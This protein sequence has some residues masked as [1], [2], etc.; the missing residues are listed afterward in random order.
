[1]V[2]PAQA[3]KANSVIQF[4]IENCVEIFGEEV[5]MLLEYEED[6]GDSG[7]DTDSIPETNGN[8]CGHL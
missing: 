7:T 6:K 3:K 4:M 1:M 8:T 5:K 2:Q